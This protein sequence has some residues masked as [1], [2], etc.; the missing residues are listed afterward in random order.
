MSSYCSLDTDIIYHY[1]D[2]PLD[3][4]ETMFSRGAYTSDVLTKSIESRKNRLSG[5][6]LSD[7]GLGN[8]LEHISFMF[9]E[10][11]INIASI[12]RNKHKRYKKGTVLYKHTVSIH[13]LDGSWWEIV[14]SPEEVNLIRTSGDLDWDDPNVYRKYLGELSKIIKANGYV[15]NK[16][17]DLIQ[18][19]N[20]FSPHITSYFKEWANSNDERKLEQYSGGVPHI[21]AYPASG[22][23]EV[24]CVDKV[25]LK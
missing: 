7:T 1:S 2:R 10:L 18:I 12:F 4:I 22:K 13:D 8:Y 16:T 17:K 23:V 24:S 21:M 9:N 19:A 15:G 20:T 11:P 6:G 14:S 25:V 5:L 3:Y